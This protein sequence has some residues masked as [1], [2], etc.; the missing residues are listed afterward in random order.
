MDGQQGG[1]PTKLAKAL[2]T[3]VSQDETRLRFPAGADAVATF[4]KKASDLL[5]DTQ[6]NREMS[7]NLAHDDV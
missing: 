4:E 6:A 2:V 1:D 7:R 5:A 3:L